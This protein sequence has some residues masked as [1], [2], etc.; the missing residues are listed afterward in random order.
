MALSRRFAQDIAPIWPCTT[1]PF[2]LRI[3]PA[4]DEDQLFIVRAI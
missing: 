4:L 3:D 1:N 2:H